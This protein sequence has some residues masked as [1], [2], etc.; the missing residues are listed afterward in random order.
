MKKVIIALLLFAVFYSGLIIYQQQMMRTSMSPIHLNFLAY[1]VASFIL[2]VGLS[3]FHRKSLIQHSKKGMIWGMLTGL[4]ASIIG[5]IS[6]MAGLRFSSSINWSLISRLSL[7]TTFLLVALFLHEKI[8]KEKLLALTAALI[9]VVMVVYKWGATVTFNK[10]DVFFILAMVGMSVGNILSKKAMEYV[11][12]I[13]LSLYRIVSA[14]ILLSMYVLFF[15]PIPGAIDWIPPI[16]MGSCFVFG[17]VLVNYVIQHAGVSFFTIGA[18]L[19]PVFV[20]LFSIVFL[21][22]RPMFTQLLGGVFIISSIF[23]FEHKSIRKHVKG[24]IH[25]TTKVQTIS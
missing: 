22:E 4:S 9:G 24:A 7:P 20:M 23:I 19:V 1:V 3:L 2:I 8:T 13:Q 18:T 12:S 17:I 21:Q 10:G 15:F 11:S 16:I 6:A 5:D 14:A 25:G